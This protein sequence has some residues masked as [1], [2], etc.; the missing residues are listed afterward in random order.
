MPIADTSHRKSQ[1]ASISKAHLVED[2]NTPGVQFMINLKCLYIYSD[3]TNAIGPSEN[4]QK[5]CPRTLFLQ[6]H[7]ER[8]PLPAPDPTVQEEPSQPVRKSRQTIKLTE[9]GKYELYGHGPY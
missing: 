9:K 3:W 7:N 8:S 6:R 1:D 2:I 4:A 5:R